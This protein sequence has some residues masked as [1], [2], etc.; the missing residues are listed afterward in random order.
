MQKEMQQVRGLCT[1]PRRA[2]RTA[3]VAMESVL[4]PSSCCYSSFLHECQESQGMRLGRAM[5]CVQRTELFSINTHIELPC[6]NSAVYRSICSCG[7]KTDSSCQ[8]G[9]LSCKR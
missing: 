1:G 9:L 3:P 8:H 7:G 6:A 4:R 5:L 2:S